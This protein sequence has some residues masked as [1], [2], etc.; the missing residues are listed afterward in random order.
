MFQTTNQIISYHDLGSVDNHRPS[1]LA[2]STWE[3]ARG[4]EGQSARSK[5]VR[6]LHGAH[7]WSLPWPCEEQR[8][9]KW[10]EKTIGKTMEIYG[11]WWIQLF[12]FVGRV[13]RWFF[14]GYGENINVFQFFDTNYMKKPFTRENQCRFLNHLEEDRPLGAGG[15]DIAN[16]NKA[17]HSKKCV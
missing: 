13:S 6:F 16:H 12:V 3:G 7:H 10:W 9:Q 11:T 5:A 8:C 2:F 4:A 1:L 14:N 17:S 15:N